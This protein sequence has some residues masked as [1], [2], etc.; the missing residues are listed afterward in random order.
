MGRSPSAPEAMDGREGPSEATRRHYH[1]L[2][3]GGTPEESLASALGA[4]AELGLW[5]EPARG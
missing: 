1:A 5:S 3:T 2:D 4:L